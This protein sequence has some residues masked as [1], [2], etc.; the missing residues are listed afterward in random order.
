MTTD[1]WALDGPV[2][3]YFIDRLEVHRDD[4]V[5]FRREVPAEL[6]ANT[7][8]RSRVR[9]KR[10]V[11][12]AVTPGRSGASECLAISKAMAGADGS[13]VGGHG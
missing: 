2:V 5:D 3:D 13:D 9:L 11:V 4:R 6:P 1:L 7:A 10:L 8:G 12:A